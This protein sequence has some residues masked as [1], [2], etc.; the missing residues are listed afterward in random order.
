ML[1]LRLRCPRSGQTGLRLE[2]GDHL[3]RRTPLLRVFGDAELRGLKRRRGSE[4]RRLG[5]ALNPQTAAVSASMN[6]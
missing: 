4:E 5:T 2:S 3:F 1:A 6:S